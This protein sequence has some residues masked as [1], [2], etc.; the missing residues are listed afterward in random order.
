MLEVRTP[1]LFVLVGL[2]IIAFAFLLLPLLVIVAS[3]LGDTGYLAFPP[4]GFTLKWYRM[5]LDEPRYL[6]SFWTSLKIGLVVSALSTIVG[7]LSSYALARSRFVGLSFLEALFLSPLI[8]PTLVLALGLSLYFARIGVVAGTSRLIAAH[9]VI[10]TPYVVR[11]TLPLFRRFDAALDEAARN[12]GAS[13]V[14]SF[15]LVFL[16]AV[17]PAIIAAGVM[18]FLTSFDEVVLA[19]FLADPKAPT[20]PVII[21]SAVQL[22]FEPTVAA[23][24]GLLVVATTILLASVQGL[25][26]LRR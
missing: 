9:T 21:Y 2:S 10:C 12:L 15:F 24:S 20:L 6:T 17:R 8:L 5:A 3:P 11:V 4:Q 13:P 26:L 1:L 25:R 22:G 19:L 23:V 7:T 16:P 18:A 14:Q